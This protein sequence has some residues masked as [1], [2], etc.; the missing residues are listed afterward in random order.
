M[1]ISKINITNS[2]IFF[3]N[4]TQAPQNFIP[5]D[6]NIKYVISS[7]GNVNV[8]SSPLGKNLVPW[9]IY[10][11]STHHITYSISNCSV[12]NII[13]A[14]TMKYPNGGTTKET[15]YGIVILSKFITLQ[16]FYYIPSFTVNL[17]F[18]T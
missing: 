3:N 17:I 8:L 11:E 5:L 10:I 16:G 15:I 13:P 7:T 2:S 12:N 6:S 14:F 9:I 1:E 18:V 4:I